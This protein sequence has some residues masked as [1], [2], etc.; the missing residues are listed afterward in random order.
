M[1]DAD[2]SQPRPQHQHEHQ[3]QHEPRPQPEPQSPAQLFA[4]D[5]LYSLTYQSEAR[6]FE[7]QTSWEQEVDHLSKCAARLDQL[8][9]KR[10]LDAATNKALM[11]QCLRCA[12]EDR[13]RHP[14]ARTAPAPPQ[15]ETF[16][17]QQHWSDDQTDSAGS[18]HH[19]CHLP[20]PL[21]PQQ[22]PPSVKARWQYIL[23]DQGLFMVA[24]QVVQS[25]PSQQIGHSETRSWH[26]GG[27]ASPSPS[28]LPRRHGPLGYLESH[29]ST[30]SRGHIPTL[31]HSTGQHTQTQPRS[32]NCAP[33]TSLAPRGRITKPGESGVDYV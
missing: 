28:L 23:T 14:C 15:T 24:Q 33:W 29:H 30:G 17:R 27:E 6:I 5:V 2:T 1:E 19:A 26:K 11:D 12:L 3:P 20:V 31:S 10:Q 16:S 8:I 22:A 32:A 18:Q 25:V 7:S 21:L 13:H 4:R 9:N